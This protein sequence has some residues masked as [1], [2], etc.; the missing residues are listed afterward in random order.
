MKQKRL[1][2]RFFLFCMM[3]FLF[4]QTEHVKADEKQKIKLNYK[5]E[6]KQKAQNY[7]NTKG[8]ERKIKYQIMSLLEK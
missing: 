8:T 5:T 7:I 4:I 2:I 1:M 3:M 6:V